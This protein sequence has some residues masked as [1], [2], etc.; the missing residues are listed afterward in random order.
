MQLTAAEQQQ[1]TAW[2]ARM[3]EARQRRQTRMNARI[4]WFSDRFE[5]GLQL[6]MSQRLR[7]AC[8][9]LRDQIVINL[10]VPV[11]KVRRKRTRDTAW[12]AKGSSYTWVDPASRS[13]PGEY[14]HAET[15]RLMKDVFYDMVT[16]LRGIVG[17]SLKY[18]VRLELEMNRS[19]LRRTLL[20]MQPII[21]DILT[22]GTSAT[23]RII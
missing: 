11:V 9:L 23:M 18:G 12:G 14:P 3:S 2:H 20:E 8:Q 17:T 22:R 10:S 15:T 5:R 19:F 16:P 1:V 4:V 6:T 21:A 13:R 7:V